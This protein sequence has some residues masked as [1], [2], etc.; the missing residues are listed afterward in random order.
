MSVFPWE[1]LLS[2]VNINLQVWSGTFWSV[3]LKTQNFYFGLRKLS[4]EFSKIVV[5]IFRK[6]CQKCIQR[7]QVKVFSM[8][9]K[10]FQNC[11]YFGFWNEL[12]PDF[13][14]KV[15]QSYHHLIP[16]CWVELFNRKQFFSERKI[17]ISF[18]DFDRK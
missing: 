12:S 15:H 13:V 6:V 4:E 7:V 5:K 1:S 2:V 9:W 18:S 16:T 17:Y 10:K 14:R 8:F 3:F 11:I